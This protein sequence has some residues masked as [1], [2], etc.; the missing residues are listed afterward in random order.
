MKTLKVIYDED[1]GVQLEV[2]G[3]KGKKCMDLTKDLEKELSGGRQINRKFKPEYYAND[4][5][6]IKTR[7]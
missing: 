6:T 4:V 3:A 5:E 7:K 1:G 2:E